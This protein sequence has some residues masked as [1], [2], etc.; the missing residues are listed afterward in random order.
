[1]SQQQKRSKTEGSSKWKTK[2]MVD[3]RN[4]WTFGIGGTQ[5]QC[6]DLPPMTG[7]GLNPRKMV[8]TGGWFI[9]Y[10]SPTRLHHEVITSACSRSLVRGASS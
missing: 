4:W 9:E 6:H 5:L 7:N 10:Y 8:M 1:M 2:F 3:I